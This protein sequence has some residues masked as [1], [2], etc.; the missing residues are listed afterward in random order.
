[1]IPSD[2][3]KKVLSYAFPEDGDRIMTCSYYLVSEGGTLCHADN[4]F[5]CY[6]RATG[7]E[8]CKS[9]EDL[10][11]FKEQIR[12]VFQPGEKDY[13][14]LVIK[15]GLCDERGIFSQEEN[16]MK[17][18]DRWLEYFKEDFDKAREEGRAESEAK[19]AESEAKYAKSEAECKKLE[20]RY[21][22]SET[23]RKE[24]AKKVARLEEEMRKIKAAML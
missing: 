5:D 4:P 19:Y 24:L 14:E 7:V 11:T 22:E 8:T 17:M 12:S 3:L 13:V 9:I 16:G 23:E 15:Y 21:A 2:R 10:E 20:A 1:M 18:Y 6:N